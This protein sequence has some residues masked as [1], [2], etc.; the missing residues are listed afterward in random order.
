MALT[1]DALVA[2]D[3]YR[4]YHAADDDETFALRGVSVSVQPGELVAITG[5]SGSGK[6]TLLACLAGV[7]EPDGG[8]VSVAGQRLTRRP[9]AERARLRARYIG[10]VFQSGNLID[11]LSVSDNILLARRLCRRDAHRASAFE[12]VG[13]LLEALDLQGR[14]RWR[15]AELSGGEAARASLAVGLANHP[16][17]LL[18]DEPTGELD[19]VQR[20]RLLDLLRR[21]LDRGTAIVVATH[22]AEVAALADRCVHLI[23]GR[24]AA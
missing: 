21:R 17:V 3:L 14:A 15:P 22:S 2:R 10:V 12:P 7:D 16:A 19:G 8:A 24:V 18:A 11:H 5:P 4:F 13:E 20:G 23:D 9:E 6:S 1:T